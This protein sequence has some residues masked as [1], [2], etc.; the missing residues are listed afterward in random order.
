MRMDGVS[1]FQS[2]PGAQF[3]NALASGNYSYCVMVRRGT[4]VLDAD[5]PTSVSLKLLPGDIVSISGLTSHR[6]RRG[7]RVSG[8]PTAFAR[9]AVELRS[10]EAPVDLLIG[11]VKSEALALGTLRSGPLLIR[12]FEHPDLARRIWNAA[13]MLEDEYAEAPSPYRH[14]VVRRLAEIIA[15]NISRRTAQHD[16]ETAMPDVGDRIVHA[17][18]AFFAE[19]T[20]DWTLAKLSRAAG[21]SRTRFIEGFKQASGGQP[22]VRIMSRIRLAASARRLV[23]E[24]L[25]IEL[26]AEDA[27][28]GSAAAFIRAFQREFGETPG[29]WR[30]RQQGPAPDAP[31]TSSRQDLQRSPTRLNSRTPT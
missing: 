30:R 22:P 21:M 8:A 15:I 13:T 28:Y 9:E 2:R 6:F 26:A 29:R 18:D 16:Q 7:P 4:L 20:A 17:L 27:G 19:P 11:E 10:A 24:N 1:F 23:D 25:S 31:R 3:Q 5:Y 12:P 14:R